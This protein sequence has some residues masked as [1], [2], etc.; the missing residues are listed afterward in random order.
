MKAI[1]NPHWKKESAEGLSRLASY[2]DKITQEPWT[3]SYELEDLLNKIN[4]STT[5]DEI[6]TQ[7]VVDYK[8]LL[9]RNINPSDVTEV[10]NLTARLAY[11]RLGEK[12]QDITYTG[13]LLEKISAS[14]YSKLSKAGFRGACL[15][16]WK[17]GLDAGITTS[18]S[19][20]TDNWHGMV[21][22]DKR[23]NNK[24]N[25]LK[26]TLTFRQQQILNFICQRGLTNQ[27]IAKQLGLSDST[28]KM[29]I[30]LILKKYGVQHRSQLIVALQKKNG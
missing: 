8:T 6:P 30:G 26:I 14:D 4:C 7:V 10:I 19:F 24:H 5:R 25:D 29:H 17:F 18:K 28:V 2:A 1:V 12:F 13:T 27:Q 21:S 3:I 15:S 22:A 9:E 20:L 23:T 16:P 11:C